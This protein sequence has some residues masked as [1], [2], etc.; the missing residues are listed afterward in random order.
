MRPSALLP[1]H[2]PRLADRLAAAR[3]GRFVG[4]QAEIEM[5][6]SALLADEPSFA[7]L[8]VYGPGGVGKTALLREFVRVAAELGR[9]VVAIDGRN[10]DPSPPGVLLALR[11]AMGLPEGGTVPTALE[12]PDAGVWLIDTYETLAPLDAWLRE[13][14]LPQLPAGSLVVLAGRNPPAPAWRTDLDWAALTR[15]VALRN[16][17]PGESETY[18]AA[19]EIPGDQHAEVLAFTH[20]HPLALALVADALRRDGKLDTFNPRHEPDVVRV[21]LERLVRDVPSPAHRL[22]LE[23]CVLVWATT[24]TLLTDV[25][26]PAEAHDLFAWLRQLSFI[27]Q[28]PHGLYP[29][30]LAREVLDA[31]LRWRD[32]RGHQQLVARLSSLLFARFQ[33]AQA[34]GVEQQR[35][36]FDL[37]YLLR[38]SPFFGPYFEWAALGAAYAEPAAARDHPAIL[39]MIGQ[40]E[41]DDAVRIGRH[42][43]A[44][45][46]GAFLVFRDIAGAVFGFMAHLT[47]HDAAPADIAAD[48]AVAAALDF[49]QRHGPARPGEE[50]LHLRF[51]MHRD[52]YQGVSPALNLAAINS[53]IHWTSSPKLAWNFVAVADPEFHEPHFT[54]IHIWRSP[55]ADFEVGG[56]RYGIFAHDW[57]VE[58]AAAWMGFKYDQGADVGANPDQPRVPPP[59]VLVLVLSREEFG[60]AVRQALRDFTRP[61]RLA[62]NPLA[63]SRLVGDA[64]EEGTATDTL[65]ALVRIATD[66][67]T[68]NPKDAKLHR[69]LWHTY[70]VPAPTQE[71][72]AELLDLP[73]NTYRYHLAKGIERVTAW[74]WQRELAGIDR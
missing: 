33:A 71:Q 41:G 65:R 49:A 2:A 13:T 35:I 54:G 62:T 46:P 59:P 36:W 58:P 72:A 55:A 26:G 32:P 18:L 44:R 34:R 69:A 53:S 5:F 30:D 70:I 74:L 51:W 43:L 15:T 3:R 14:L 40:H 38:Q 66:T 19:R 48:Q 68:A 16:L 56:R 29:H 4:R 37:F 7:V 57:R 25:M 42:W 17:R 12:W 6:R 20:G 24:E 64:A 28:G 63:R 11:R 31:D 9:P 23:V 47:L 45:Q 50:I 21:L 73:F 8:H 22:A 52:A 1:E 39:D 67:L 10:V 27:D 60:E 61:D